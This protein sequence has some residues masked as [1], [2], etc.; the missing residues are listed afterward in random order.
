MFSSEA[1]QKTFFQTTGTISYFEGCLLL[2]KIQLMKMRQ[3]TSQVFEVDL[4]AHLTRLVLFLFI[5]RY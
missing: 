4:M 2:W 5:H 1:K 3:P